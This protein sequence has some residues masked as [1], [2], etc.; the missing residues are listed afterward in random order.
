MQLDGKEPL[1]PY[2]GLGVAVARTPERVE[3]W[4]AGLV[5]GAA[6]ERVDLSGANLGAAARVAELVERLARGGS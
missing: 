3:R 5:D 2:R 6:P 1:L 4:L